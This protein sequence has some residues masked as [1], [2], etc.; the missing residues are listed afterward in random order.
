MI[1]A[2]SPNPTITWSSQKSQESALNASFN[3]LTWSLISEQLCDSFPSIISASYVS[4]YWLPQ[5]EEA[6]PCEQ[7]RFH[8]FVIVWKN[9]RK[10]WHLPTCGTGSLAYQLGDIGGQFPTSPCSLTHQSHPWNSWTKGCA[11]RALWCCTAII[12][13]TSEAKAWGITDSRSYFKRGLG[14]WLHNIVPA[15]HMQGPRF[16]FQYWK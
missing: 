4:S 10:L 12:Q 1:Q 13:A 8:E 3:L 16:N 15:Y 2:L 5:A 7:P 6:A 9:V 14:V 11:Y